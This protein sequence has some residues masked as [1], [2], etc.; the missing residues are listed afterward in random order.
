MFLLG[1]LTIYLE[2]YLKKDQ[3]EAIL[4]LLSGSGMIVAGSLQHR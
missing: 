4:G 1:G 3:K 2:G